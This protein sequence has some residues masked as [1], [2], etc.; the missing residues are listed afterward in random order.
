MI[1]KFPNHAYVALS[2][3]LMALCTPVLAWAQ[4][5][6]R[7]ITI[8]STQRLMS[9][10]FTPSADT[11]QILAALRT[12]HDPML[13]PL[14]ERLG[15]DPR[16]ELQLYAMVSQVLV[17]KDTTRLDVAKL[18]NSDDQ[19]LIGSA[20]A[21]LIDG[22]L[23]TT[24]QLKKIM[25]DA[26]DAVQR[27]MVAS[28]LVHRA[29]LTDRTVLVGFL[30][31]NK[32]EV[33][34]YAAV[35]LLQS[36]ETAEHAK[37]LETLKTLGQRHDLR[38]TPIAMLMMIRVRTE[39]VTAA[40]PWALSV[41][42]DDQNDT[43]MRQNAVGALLALGSADGSRL[44]GQM[45]E[46]E[47]AKPAADPLQQIRLGLMAFEFGRQM[48]PD[49]VAQL[50]NSK[51][52]VVKMISAMAQQACE[53]RDAT[54]TLLKLIKEGHPLILDWALLYAE[55]CDADHARD[56]RLALIAMSTVVDEQRGRDYERAVLAAQKLVEDNT[57]ASRRLLDPL[58]HSE[59]PAV[60]EAALAGMMRADQND[61]SALVMPIWKHLNESAALENA[62][63]YAALILA[64]EGHAEAQAWLQGMVQG[65]TVQNVGFRALAGW[66]YAKL[67]NQSDELLKQVLAQAK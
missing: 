58:L 57:P 6:P 19:R 20:L 66:Y 30:T 44:L 25:T 10:I 9:G 33:R 14:F 42:I 27:V 59:N 37:A 22:N 31:N 48:Q 8:E 7:D 35:T 50:A 45:I 54:A 61:L 53:G 51:D 63:N 17:T 28:E 1:Q 38:N 16:T 36:K 52:G 34:Y 15:R 26:P 65:G 60:V 13:V 39:K 4:A 21:T 46:T 55:R 62:A 40:A 2:A 5:Q 12:T 18:L 56:I 64:H 67:H 23:I 3:I 49:Q 24:D 32:D 41:A 47:M 29:A 11:M 43:A